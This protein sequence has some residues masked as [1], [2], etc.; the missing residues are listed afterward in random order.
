MPDQPPSL[1]NKPIVVAIGAAAS[2][3]TLIAFLTGDLP[4]ILRPQTAKSVDS[5]LTPGEVV[6]SVSNTASASDTSATAISSTGRPSAFET[7]DDHVYRVQ[8]N[9]WPCERAL[10]SHSQASD[11]ATVLEVTNRSSYDVNV[12]WVGFDGVRNHWFVLRAGEYQRQET[13]V[14]HLW[15][16]SDAQRQCMKAVMAPA[17]V[18]IE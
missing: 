17:R 10:A 2:M 13:F 12:E 4:R 6:R 8:H 9:P 14:D 3:A 15:I 5:T 18:V 11:R 7:A 1:S 16:V